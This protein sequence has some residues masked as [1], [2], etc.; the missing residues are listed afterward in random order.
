MELSME[1]LE[2]AYKYGRK[3]IQ[4]EIWQLTSALCLLDKG[5]TFT[6]EQV[7]NLLSEVAR[8]DD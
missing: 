6:N 3:T 1:D 4:S 8:P 2:K 7:I 5:Y